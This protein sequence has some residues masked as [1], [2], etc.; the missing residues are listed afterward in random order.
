MRKSFRRHPECLPAVRHDGGPKVCSTEK[1]V[2][3]LQEF[4]AREFINRHRGR[5]VA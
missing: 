2:R 3:L 4:S 5:H 1:M